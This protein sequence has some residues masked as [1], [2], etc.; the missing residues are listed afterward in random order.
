[1][2]ELRRFPK[3][4]ETMKLHYIWDAYCGWC[5]GF[6]APLNEFTGNHPELD[7]S[8]TS[9]GLFVEGRIQ[10]VSQFGFMKAGN[11]Q[12]K[13]IYGSE[14]SDAYNDL[15][16]EGSTIINSN[17]PATA[18]SVLKKYVAPER[19]IEFA[20]AMQ[21]QFFIQGKSLS[22]IA[23]YVD[24]FEAFAIPPPG[25]ERATSTVAGLLPRGTRFS[26]SPSLGCYQLPQAHSRTQWQALQSGP[27]RPQRRSPRS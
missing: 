22:D 1:M 5:Y 20:H 12:I 14:F 10:Q 19:L 24:L 21:K 3:E 23:T 17:H 7:I 11:E 27:K 26:T 2:L 25:S 15:L 16:D 6:G 18:L 13:A 9:G 4:R 8:I